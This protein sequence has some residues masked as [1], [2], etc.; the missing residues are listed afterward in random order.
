MVYISV[1]TEQ[2]VKEL[3]EYQ[4]EVERKLVGMVKNFAYN[5]TVEAIDATPYNRN[6]EETSWMYNFR[7]SM[8]K[9][10]GHA[11]GGWTLSSGDYSK[12]KW[13]VVASD[14]NAFNVKQM[15]DDASEEYKL[16]ETVFI[17]NNV[18][19]I[20]NDHWP[21]S[22]I[23]SLELKSLESGYSDQAPG[24]LVDPINEVIRAMSQDLKRMYDQA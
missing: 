1:N 6:Y 14:E 8:T 9:L 19:Y 2:L 16:G 10:P 24:G 11:K 3:I 15:A 5:L 12:N 18:P 13:N 22:F 23:G 21:V 7:R 4:K 20:M 17:V